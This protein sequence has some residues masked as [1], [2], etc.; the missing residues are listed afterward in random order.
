MLRFEGEGHEYYNHSNSDLV[1]RFREM[2][3]AC[4]ERS[5]DDLFFLHSLSLSD[6]LACEPWEVVS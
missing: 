2:P 1:I 5:G 6:A 4:F 3:H